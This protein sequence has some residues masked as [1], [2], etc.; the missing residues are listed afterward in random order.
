MDTKV[1][2]AVDYR[3]SY[4][5]YHIN[6]I[7]AQIQD[8]LKE[9]KELGKINDMPEGIVNERMIK[10]RIGW[11]EIEEKNRGLSNNTLREMK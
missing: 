2:S 8:L 9:L 5:N 4:I 1:K 11:A 10:E 3:R 7:S 6:C